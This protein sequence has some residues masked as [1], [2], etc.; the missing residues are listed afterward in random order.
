MPALTAEQKEHFEEYGFVHV[1]DVFDPEGTL[2][3]VI[4]EYEFVLNALADNLYKKDKISSTY[5]DLEFGERVTK[6]YGESGEIHNQF[7]DFSLP[8]N[9]VLP[10]TPFWAGKQ[11]TSIPNRIQFGGGY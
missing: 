10:D 9:G 5:S 6:I 7:F 3:P 1:P 11:F 8:L 4:D 2:D